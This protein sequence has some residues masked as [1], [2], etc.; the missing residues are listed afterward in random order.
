[1]KI[2]FLN[3]SKQSLGGG[4]SFMRNLRKG[5]ETY[6]DLQ[7]VNS[8]EEADIC[9]VSG[10]TMVT[11][12]TIDRVQELGKKLVTRLDN[13]PRNSRNRNTGTSRLKEFAERADA[14][15]WQCQW[16]KD[17]LSDFIHPKKEQII[18]NGVDQSIFKPEG[19]KYDFLLNPNGPGPVFLY[20]RY[21]RDETKNWEMAWYEFQKYHQLRKDGTLVLVG[22]FSP[23]QLEYNF[24][25]FRGEVVKYIPPVSDP[26]EMAKI[27]RGCNYFLATY[28]NDCFSNTYIE[29]I[30]CG[31]QLTCVEM[32]GGTPEILELREMYGSNYFGLER[33]TKEYYTLFNNL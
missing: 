7:I 13:V 26:N 4:W 8:I 3:D 1:M 2:H 20:S 27:M 33:M 5:L 28:I 21:N 11:R 31:V 16:A 15:V 18:H 9:F 24:D 6:T 29:A 10:P 14:V 30:S 23:E 22:N 12:Q 17:Y 25:F 19:D 32:S